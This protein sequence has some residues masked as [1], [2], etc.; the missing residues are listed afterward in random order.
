M[1][2]CLRTRQHSNLYFID[3]VNGKTSNKKAEGYS[4]FLF[5]ASR[6]QKKLRYLSSVQ[7]VRHQQINAAIYRLSFPLFDKNLPNVCPL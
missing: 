5:N 3:D 4:A 6:T 1:L 7:T 2:R